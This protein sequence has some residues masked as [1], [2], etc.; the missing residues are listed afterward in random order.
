M[1]SSYEPRTAMYKMSAES[2]RQMYQTR[3]KADKNVPFKKYILDIINNESGLL[4][5]VTKLELD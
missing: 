3:S 4:Y 1:I 5:P 2:A